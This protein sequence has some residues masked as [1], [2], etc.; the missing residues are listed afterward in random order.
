MLA[1]RTDAH[2]RSVQPCHRAGLMDALAM[3][4]DDRL[5]DIGCGDGRV[6]VW[7]A[8]D[9]HG[10][11]CVGYEIDE[12]RVKGAQDDVRN[13]G[14]ESRVDVRHGNALEAGLDGVS[15]VFLFLTTRGMRKVLPMLQAA[16]QNL[17]VVSMWFKF[18][19]VAPDE[20]RKLDDERGMRHPLYIYT[21]GGSGS[22]SVPSSQ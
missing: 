19:N 20:T 1:P 10:V 5:L 22:G 2:L 13:A 14:L 12:A 21:L 11:T 7:A 18:D 4:E 3:Q 17:R 8:Q 6:L 9:V 16:Q 15:H